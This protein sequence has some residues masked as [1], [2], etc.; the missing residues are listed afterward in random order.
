MV[1]ALFPQQSAPFISV[2]PPFPLCSTRLVNPPSAETK[3]RH[4]PRLLLV[5]SST[6]FFFSRQMISLTS[7]DAESCLKSL[8]RYPSQTAL[9]HESNLLFFVPPQI[10]RELSTPF[11]DQGR[12]FRRS[13]DRHIVFEFLAPSLRNCLRTHFPTPLSSALFSSIRGAFLARPSEFSFITGFSLDGQT[14]RK[15]SLPRWVISDVFPFLPCARFHPPSSATDSRAFPS[16][17]SALIPDSPP[18]CVYFLRAILIFK[19]L[20]RNPCQHS[21]T[22][23]GSSSSSPSSKPS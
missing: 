17:F 9:F 20:L 21:L 3:H 19:A 22:N 5:P 1:F 18:V 10:Y 6:L 2:S 12:L 23:T 16:R 7:G 4:S 14:F 8:I 13:E 15:F 11:F